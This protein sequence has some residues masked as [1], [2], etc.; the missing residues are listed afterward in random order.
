VGGWGKALKTLA[1]VR[2]DVFSAGE[3]ER[4][5]GER[6]REGREGGGEGE[7][8]GEVP[9]GK[10]ERE[11]ERGRISEGERGQMGERGRERGRLQ[12]AQG[13]THPRCK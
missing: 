13:A 11:R 6:G 10:E 8:E 9:L 4:G 7:D 3:R 12:E 5:V 2:V 1:V